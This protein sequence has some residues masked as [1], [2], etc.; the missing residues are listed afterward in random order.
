MTNNEAPVMG[1]PKVHAE[2]ERP[3]PVYEQKE[4]AIPPQATAT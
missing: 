1:V 4:I 2:D 3:T